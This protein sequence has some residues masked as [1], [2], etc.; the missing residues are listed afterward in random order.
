MV[1]SI[2]AASVDCFSHCILCFENVG[3]GVGKGLDGPSFIKQEW[4][5]THLKIIRIWVDALYTFYIFFS[6]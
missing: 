2:V 5:G 3:R 4:V 6:S 1:Q